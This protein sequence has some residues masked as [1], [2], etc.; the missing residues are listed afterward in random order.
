MKRRLLVLLTVIA[1]IIGLSCVSLTAY[2]DVLD[3]SP[4][5]GTDYIKE[6]IPAGKLKTSLQSLNFDAS[7]VSGVATQWGARGIEAENPISGSGSIWMSSNDVGY[8]QANWAV[9]AAKKDIGR[10]Y[11]EFDVKAVN[12]VGGLVI[13]VSGG[14]LDASKML[15]ELDLSISGTAVAI[16]SSNIYGYISGASESKYQSAS[17]EANENGSYH[18]YFEYEIS[19]SNAALLTDGN[20][21]HIWFSAAASNA[22]DN[23]II[24]DNVDFGSVTTTDAVTRY[25]TIDWNESYE[26]YEV[27]SNAAGS[28]PI[29]GNSA[30]IVDDWFEG[31]ALAL[32]TGNVTN[33]AIGGFEGRSDADHIGY[34][35]IQNAGKNYIEIVIDQE[36]CSMINIWTAGWYTAVIYNGESWHSEGYITGFSAA[37]L[38]QGWK[39]SY[40]I[41]LP[42]EN[43]NIDFNINATANNGTVY[44][45]NLKV[46]SEDYAPYVED[47]SY[48]LIDTEDVEVEVELKGKDMSSLSLGGV[49]IESSLYSVSGGVL[50]I[51]KS[52]FADNAASYSFVLTSEGGSEAFVITKNDNRQHVTVS[53]GDITK[54]YD[55]TTDVAA[56][57]LVLGGIAAGDDVQVSYDSAV[58]DS[59][60]VNA[61][62]VT[63]SGIALSG[64][65]ASRYVL[66]SNELEA[67]ATITK[68]SVSV[69]ADAK[70]KVEGD[71]DPAL[72]YSA[73]GLIG[74]D[75]L[76]GA[77]SRADGETV[78]EY[79]I[80]V[81]SLANENYE[82]NYTGAKLTVTAR[83]VSGDEGSGSSSSGTGNN[84]GSNAG[85]DN[86]GNAGS[87][88]VEPDG[89]LSTGAIV[90]IV[91]AVVAVVAIAGA[92]IVII[93]KKQS[94]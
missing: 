60:S 93:K 73:D 53:A 20:D 6:E 82:I 89:G 81:G 92:V 84:S 38:D 66:D 40:C 18:V 8:A 70:E 78:G 56:I 45:D 72:T 21:P 50:T 57:Q 79:D 27:G 80:L 14:Y 87:G 37:A 32:A 77:L 36:N 75:I 54:V 11:V 13:S 69:V 85:N 19:E 2:A 74:E 83:P 64:D 25:Y 33:A 65:D 41:D 15:A 3:M 30:S 44:I 16:D 9:M 17:V 24:V 91:I 1:L 42:V 90:G 68:K 31:K 59:S 88:S 86:N 49:A 46:V 43:Y 62:K 12:N 4:V 76:S 5:E 34:K 61:T 10:Y 71:S 52:I 39:L 35:F 47:G 67:S 58:Y 7:A 51:D 23:K 28:Q 55:G 29:W 22:T 26:S 48:N 63:F 94:K